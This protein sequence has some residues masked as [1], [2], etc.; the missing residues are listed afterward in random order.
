MP[1]VIPAE[2]PKRDGNLGKKD[3][4]CQT[5]STHQ[6]RP[7]DDGTV[8][9]LYGHAIA[10]YRNGDYRRA[11]SFCRDVLER[12][13]LHAEAVHL[14]GALALEAGQAVVALLHLHHSTLLRPGHAPFH[15]A[16][17][18]AYRVRGDRS[19]AEACFQT[20][21][22][23]DPTLAAAHNGLGMILSDQGQLA[24]AAA[25]F[26]QSLAIKPDQPRAL[27]N[28][29]Q[30]LHRNGDLDGAAACFAGAIRLKPDYAIPHNNLG[31]VF[32]EQRK[33]VEAIV[34]LRRAIA[35]QPDYPEAHCNL[36]NIFRNQGDPA[37]IGCYQEA[38]RFRPEYVKAHC[39]LGIALAAWGRRDE[40]L[41]ALQ[42]ALKLAPDSVETL[43]N[44]GHI[45]LQQARWE[46][47]QPVFERV[48]SLQPD[49]AEAFANLVRIRE[50]LC[51]WRTRD[52]D[53][54]R[55]RR[56]AE[57]RLAGGRRPAITPFNMMTT[58]WSL[59]FQ[60]AVA[61]R[62][63]EDIVLGA[64]PPPAFS[65]LRS[66][67]GR[68]R[69]GYIG[70]TFHH[71]ALMQL[72][73]GLF[74]LHDRREF[75]VFIYSYGP[76]DGSTYRQRARRD[77]DQF[78]DLAGVPTAT[79]ARRIYDDG[80]HILVDLMGH[81]GGAREEIV[82]LRPA[83]I[84]VSYIGFAGTCGAS[85]LDYLIS[86]RTVTPPEMAAG[87]SE[88][89][90]LLPNC[91]LVTDREQEIATAPVRRADYGL[92]ES[93]FVFTCFN[94]S[95]KFEPGIFDVWAKI[96]GQVPGSVLWLYSSGAT[97]ERNLRREATARGLASDRIIFAAHET[98]TKHLARLR[99][100]DLFLDTPV[101][102]AHTGACDALWAGLP[103]LTC[104]GQTFA[105]RVAA[106]LLTNIGQPEL[107]AATHD[108]YARRAVDLAQRPNELSRLREK[109]AANR[110]TW[111]LFDTTRVTRHL[112]QAYRA[113]WDSYA[114]G[115]PP[116]GIVVSESGDAQV[117]PNP[118]L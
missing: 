57:E 38:I 13:P 70:G 8:T 108:E 27:T 26:R 25:S 90:V 4:H 68:L 23:L 89:L 56:D 31:A 40:A 96:L 107:I 3:A 10:H 42:S 28:L 102:N 30:V 81:T 71:H 92:P 76:D 49:H 41:A 51:D 106:S 20:A 48:L 53:F 109:L 84:Q 63:S 114:A 100:A 33:F 19:E 6:K 11:E 77:C 17:G 60:L 88:R 87:Y 32:N 95:Y 99:L 111:P 47:A 83:P 44:I 59:D 116:A 16:L 66:R 72:M 110:T 115:K 55:L 24:R 101:V 36:G 29:G 54:A 105:S 74:G 46:A 12:E 103:V 52:A 35:L 1:P 104:P 22:R 93:G 34:H 82:A 94:N 9:T 58:D 118:P 43:E 85:F 86:D 91:Y 21:L 61:R 79:A 50:L 98:K 64:G 39:Y 18:E 2:N 73:M 112:E 15:H 69:I 67:T 45:I 14:L 65:F 97:V 62:F 37:A 117:K 75:E 5:Q 7:Q 113:M 80:V 78:R